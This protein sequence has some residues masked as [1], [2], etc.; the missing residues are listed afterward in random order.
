MARRKPKDVQNKAAPV[1]RV[2]LSPPEREAFVRFYRDSF[3]GEQA[4][5][6]AGY[7]DAASVWPRLLADPEVQARL[8]GYRSGVDIPAR[9]PDA[10]FEHLYAQ[11]FKGLDKILVPDVITGEIRIDWEEA[12]AQNGGALEVE[13]SISDRGGIP[14]R[15][16]RIRKRG[17]LDILRAMAGQLSKI[18]TDA[19]TEDDFRRSFLESIM[20]NASSAPIMTDKRVM[21]RKE[22]P[23]RSAKPD[24]ATN[25]DPE[26]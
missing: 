1:A 21:E 13:Q 23:L 3:D 14:Q 15:V 24:Q 11:A 7:K 6:S 12:A 9:T 2:P 17:N 26:P 18:S 8:R 10:M 4:A 5:R 25:D 22:K 19:P 16:V 20:K